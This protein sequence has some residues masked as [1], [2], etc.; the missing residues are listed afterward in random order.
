[1]RE[2]QDLRER[3]VRGVILSYV[4]T[5]GVNRVKTVPVSRLDDAVDGDARAMMRRTCEAAHA[6]GIRAE[7][8]L[9]LIKDA[10]RELPE[11]RRVPRHA[12]GDVL[13]RL[14]TI[15][16]HEYYARERGQ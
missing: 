13:S 3:G 8:L 6:H 4:D 7:Q 16:I 14:I 11:A 2:A 9:L 15:C 12:A 1:M 10:W 5:A